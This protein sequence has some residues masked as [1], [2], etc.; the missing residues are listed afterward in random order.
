MGKKN[1][2]DGE[3]MS[4]KEARTHPCPWTGLEVVVSRTSR[5]LRLLEGQTA[6]GGRSSARIHPNLQNIKH[7]AAILKPL[8]ELQKKQKRL[9][10]WKID[11][12]S[13]LVTAFYESHKQCY[14]DRKGCENFTPESWAF[15]QAW[16]IHKMIS[17]LRTK[18]TRDEVPHVPCLSVWIAIYKG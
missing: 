6:V 13:I 12:Y 18:A 17:K 3:G 1:F 10:A 8:V 7:N 9:S 2:P 14:E 11:V 4:V 16:T 5:G 15:E